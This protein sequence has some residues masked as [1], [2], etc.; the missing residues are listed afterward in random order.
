MKRFSSSWPRY[1]GE[2]QIPNRE[3][4]EF[5]GWGERVT[6]ELGNITIRAQWRYVGPSGPTTPT[7]PTDPTPGDSDTDDDSD[8]DP[9]PDPTPV[10][11]V[12]VNVPDAPTPLAEIGETPVPLASNPSDLI[13]IFDDDVP[14]AGGAQTGNN[15]AL[16]YLLAALSLAGL[17][18]VKLLEKKNTTK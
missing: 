14:L 7:G 4:Y 6:D 10:R 13:D 11:R 3:G 17:G 16:W 8:P 15:D 2:D 9:D 5:I 12:T 18:L 1:P